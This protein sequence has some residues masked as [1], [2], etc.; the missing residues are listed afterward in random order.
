MSPPTALLMC[1]ASRSSR[2]HSSAA[3]RRADQAEVDANH[4]AVHLNLAALHLATQDYGAVV[5]ACDAALAIDASSRKALAR[6]ARAHIGRH[7]HGEAEADLA[8][9]RGIDPGCAELA[10]LQAE[11]ARARASGAKQERETFAHMFDRPA[12]KGSSS[13]SSRAGA[14]ARPALACSD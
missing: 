11:L 4:M 2:Q 12:A 9:L 1:M 5:A 3:W 6:R 7:E 13:S 14:A 10:E 8:R